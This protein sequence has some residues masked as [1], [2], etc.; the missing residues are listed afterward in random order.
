MKIKLLG[1]G[2]AEGIPGIF[3][4]CDFCKEVIKRG[5]K[6]VRR[7]CGTILDENVLID[8]SPDLYM[9]KLNYNLDLS[10]LTDVV[11]THS[12][13]DHLN[14]TNFEM[15]LRPVFA[16]RSDNPI[17][18]YGNSLAHK[19]Y[20]EIELG[21]YSCQVPFHLIEEGK[22]FMVNGYSFTALKADHAKDQD[23]YVFLIEKDGKVFFH[24][25]DSGYYPEEVW[26]ALK[27]KKIDLAVL[28]C[29][30]G[31]LECRENHMGFETCRQV[32]ER[33]L[34]EGIAHDS[35]I[36]AITHFSHNAHCFHQDLVDR[37]EPL[38]FTVAYDGIEFDL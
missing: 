2:A 13:S 16:I 26:K 22:P 25:H 32:K 30:F 7:R 17:N 4:E 23:C 31:F 35:T 5:G 15:A 12:H 6:D 11:Q 20:N 27:G 9:H 24:G 28:D 18:L 38:G 10:K 3:C 19:M 33:M 29:V 1:T 14:I 34:A 21:E 37:A 36:F 8:A